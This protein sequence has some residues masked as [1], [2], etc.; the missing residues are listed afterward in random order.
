MPDR[1]FAALKLQ[2]ARE[3]YFAANPDAKND[4]S[5]IWSVRKVD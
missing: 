1:D 4:P 5:L 3:A 2:R